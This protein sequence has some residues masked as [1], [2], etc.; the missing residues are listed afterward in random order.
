MSDIDILIWDN[1]IFDFDPQKIVDELAGGDLCADS[2][3]SALPVQELFRKL[4]KSVIIDE[5]YRP[6]LAEISNFFEDLS[7]ER[8]KHLDAAD[9]A[10]ES[11]ALRNRPRFNL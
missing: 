6:A 7:S 4:S 9:M 1:L 3:L 5:Q 10:E 11:Y 8:E 2:T